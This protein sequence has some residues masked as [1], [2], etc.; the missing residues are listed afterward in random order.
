MTDVPYVALRCMF[1]PEILAIIFSSIDRRSLY[2]SALVCHSWSYIALDELWNSMPYLLPLLKVLAPMKKV[3]DV[4]VSDAH[5]RSHELIPPL[6]E[7]ASGLLN[8]NWSRFDSYA[9]RIY[10]LDGRSEYH[11]IS[12]DTLLNLIS[13]L[14]LGHGPILPNITHIDWDCNRPKSQFSFFSHILPLA[15][16]SL[17]SLYLAVRGHA[18]LIPSF[19]H[20]LEGL[21]GRTDVRI[22]EIW[23]NYYLDQS[24]VSS[25]ALAAFLASQTRLETVAVYHFTVSSPIGES[26]GR[27][28]RLSSFRGGIFLGERFELEAFCTHLALGCPLLASLDLNLV[29]LSEVEEER[30]EPLQFAPLKPLLLSTGLNNLSVNFDGGIVIC[31]DDIA[32]MG[33]AWTQLNLLAITFTTPISTL[34]EFARHFSPAL[35]YLSLTA[36]FPE[37]PSFDASTPIFSSLED[38]TI[39]GSVPPEM[40]ADV[41]AVLSWVCPPT[42][43]FTFYGEHDARAEEVWKR[44]RDMAKIGHRLQTAAVERYKR[45][46]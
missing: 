19:S 30:L 33:A 45:D 4:W 9:R 17:R 3:G 35:Q 42:I 13:C 32:D 43:D 7:F 14:P 2:S 15:S 27:L 38:L 29:R 1:I 21:A 46:E 23:V 10:R 31:C 20:A 28:K 16:P 24:P 39:T 18:S 5:P 12:N 34:S 8:P 26:L 11:Q 36:T 25:Q 44:V 6:Q 40:A 22:S 41:A 37:C